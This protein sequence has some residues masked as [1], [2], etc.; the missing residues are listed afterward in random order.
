MG[1]S[2]STD[3][4]LV[5]NTCPSR[6]MDSN[7]I[8]EVPPPNERKRKRDSS[9]DRKADEGENVFI[10][11]RIPR[12]STHEP[13]AGPRNI[14]VDSAWPSEKGQLKRPKN[15][16][17]SPD[18]MSSGVCTNKNHALAD[19]NANA[20][21]RKIPPKAGESHQR[22]I[23]D[24]KYFWCKH[25]NHSKGI[26]NTTHKTEDHITNYR[27]R[28][29]QEQQQQQKQRNV[30]FRSDSSQDG[31]SKMNF[32]R[33]KNHGRTYQKQNNRRCGE[34]GRLK[35]GYLNGHSNGQ[36]NNDNSAIKV[37]RPSNKHY[38]TF[39]KQRI[40]NTCI[41]NHN[42]FR[43]K[44][45]MQVN[46]AHQNRGTEM[47]NH[48][49]HMM[50]NKREQRN[51]TAKSSISK[52]PIARIRNVAI[53]VG[54]TTTKNVASNNELEDRDANYRT[55][56]KLGRNFN[57]MKPKRLGKAARALLGKNDPISHPDT[58]KQMTT[59]RKNARNILIN[60]PKQKSDLSMA[61]RTRPS[62]SEIA[63]SCPKITTDNFDENHSFHYKIISNPD[64]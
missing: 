2:A 33:V 30:S 61:Q 15:C 38:M 52:D 12:K 53:D 9:V 64:I 57:Q 45:E 18:S 35:S 58:L 8:D 16:E 51:S 3:N 40:N 10:K 20:D 62:S 27:F 23:G 26:W 48:D 22:S 34:N 29:D 56:D 4:D 14:Y 63:R 47:N 13:K 50:Q 37:H 19:N 60:Q 54:R 31:A 39:P 59:T 1:Q 32:D 49:R 36:V 5:S 28:K 41:R 44:N 42:T 24:R 55:Q 46:S 6:S 17:Q 11:Q 25:C 43:H 21:F 7:Q